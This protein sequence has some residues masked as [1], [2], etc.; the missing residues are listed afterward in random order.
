MD[1]FRYAQF[2][3]LA[4]AS[5]IL[6]HRW[7]IPILRELLV[8]P[9]RFSDLR[10]RLPGL[11]SS[12]LADRLAGLEAQGVITRRVLDPPAASTVYE[13]T[14]DG[15]AVGPA[16]TALTRWGLRFLSMPEPGDHVE[17][18]WLLL[19]IEAFAAAGAVPERRFELRPRSGD[20]EARLRVGGGAGGTRFLD[21]DDEAPVD[22]TIEAPVVTTMLLMRGALPP[23]AA[24]AR[25]D[26]RIEGDLAA[27]ADLPSLFDFGDPQG[28]DPGTAR[29]PSLPSKGTPT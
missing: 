22:A 8:G 11:S 1:A 14:A 16:L 19:A 2:C 3:P 9:Q 5:E 13:L 21:L 17:P 29:P 25:D 6:G 28:G 10:R 26:V 7:V 27:V 18:D 15:R 4:R 23:E 24:A 20:R 12:M